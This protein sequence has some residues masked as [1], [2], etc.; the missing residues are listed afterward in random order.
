MPVG[1]LDDKPDETFARIQRIGH[2]D[3]QAPLR[4]DFELDENRLAEV[5]VRLLRL[6]AQH[7]VRRLTQRV[8]PELGEPRVCR[9][10][11][12]Y[13]ARAVLVHA[14]FESSTANFA[15]GRMAQMMLLEIVEGLFERRP[16]LRRAVVSRTSLGA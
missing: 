3:R 7:D 5:V 2:A 12:V 13:R 1:P 4:L 15:R 14:E 8:R 10:A 16:E 6:D 9:A 11:H